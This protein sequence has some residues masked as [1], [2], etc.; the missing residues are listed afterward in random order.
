MDGSRGL[1]EATPSRAVTL[2]EQYCRA[3]RKAHTAEEKCVETV[4]RV[5]DLSSLRFRNGNLGWLGISKDQGRFRES[6]GTEIEVNLRG[7]WTKMNKSSQKGFRAM[8]EVWLLEDVI[9]RGFQEVRVVWSDS[10]ALG[11]VSMGIKLF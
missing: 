1:P 11:V 4:S 6:R 10:Q 3:E 9:V 2:V 8:E 7:F 5:H